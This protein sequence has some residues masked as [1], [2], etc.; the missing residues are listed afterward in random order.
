LSDVVVDT[1]AVVALL[2]GQPEGGE[3]AHLLER[4]DRRLMSAASLVELG[5]ALGARFGPVGTAVVE[6]LLKAAELEI[7]L[8]DHEQADLAIDAWHR[9]GKGQHKAGLNY[10]DCFSYALAAQS[11]APILCVG[12]D[13]AFTD[14]EV[15]RPGRS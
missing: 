13:F 9:F 14:L 11:G 8:V 10:G 15:I 2:T 4:I 6:R 5:I 7:A 1:S 3:V 12:G